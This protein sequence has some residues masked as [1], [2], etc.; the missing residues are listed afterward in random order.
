[1]NKQAT[2]EPID[3]LLLDEAAK[4]LL[5]YYVYRKFHNY[6]SSITTALHQQYQDGLSEGL[7][8]STALGRSMLF[9]IRMLDYNLLIEI[10]GVYM[11]VLSCHKSANWQLLQRSEAKHVLYLRGYDFEAAFSISDGIAGGISTMDTEG[12]TLKLPSL[13]Q[14]RIFKVLSPKEVDWDTVTA[15]RFYDDFDALIQ[16]IN[17]RPAAVYLNAQ[18]WK[19]GVLELIP[20]MDHY[21]VY[22]SSLTESALWELDQLNTDQRRERVTVVFDEDAIAKKETQLA[23]QS[24]LMGRLGKAIWTKQGSPPSLTAAQ[25]RKGLAEVF[26]VMSPGEFEANIE[27]VKRH[28]DESSAE[29]KPGERETWL[30][31]EF[32]PAV[33]SEDLIRLKQMSQML[34][35]LVEAGQTGP[36]ECLPLFVAQLQLRI[37]LTLLL[38][39]HAATGRTLAA[40]SAV[41]Q[42]A[43]DYYTSMGGGGDAFSEE[44]RTRSLAMLD[45][46]GGLTDYAGRRL[47]AYGRSHE[48]MNQ[49]EQANATWDA[50]FNAARATVDKV[51]TGCQRSSE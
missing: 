26:K 3:F 49:S 23:T 24:A 6:L 37:Y 14:R 16:W 19:Q 10:I 51:F 33:Q 7:I 1:M 18:H 44:N 4:T 15:E 32:Y 35:K 46:H 25:V 8:R 13:L 43:S 27:D 40:Y 50:I 42:S 2:D 21:I 45:D 31:F 11:Y 5:G 22:L 41:M 30:D 34:E 20:R 38:G 39:D 36:I 12:F 48:F 17:R 29:I 9:D 47:L 28:I